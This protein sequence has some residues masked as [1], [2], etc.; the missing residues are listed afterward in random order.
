MAMTFPWGTTTVMASVATAWVLAVPRQV[1]PV[2]VVVGT[3]PV[4]LGCIAV[5]ALPR[6]FPTDALGG[7]VFG[8]GLVVLLDGLLHKLTVRSWSASGCHLAPIAGPPR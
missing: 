5:I 4:G 6:H 1:R 3:F 8:V 2:A 7:V